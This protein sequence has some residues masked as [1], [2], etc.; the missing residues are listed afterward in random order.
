MALSFGQPSEL[1]PALDLAE[2][3][4]QRVPSDYPALQARIETLVIMGRIADARKAA[5]SLM[6]FYPHFSISTW[7]LRAPHR[8]AVI[9]R[10]VQIY[11]AAGIPE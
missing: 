8:P 5:Q 10:H 3:V 7:R 2:K 6:S 4:L 9:D 11:R 1:A